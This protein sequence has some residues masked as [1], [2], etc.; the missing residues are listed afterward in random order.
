[1]RETLDPI[2]RWHGAGH[3]VAI[4]TVVRVGGSAP[5]PVGSRLVVAGDGEFAGSVS[6]GCVENA[7]I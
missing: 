1:M 2:V 6:G 7:V 4:A 5:R 3:R